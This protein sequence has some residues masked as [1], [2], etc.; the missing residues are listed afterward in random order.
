MSA[1][2]TKTKGVDNKGLNTLA[3]TGAQSK[4]YAQM[5]GRQNPGPQGFPLRSIPSREGKEKRKKKNFFII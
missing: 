1:L 4:L 2:M 5:G 3:S